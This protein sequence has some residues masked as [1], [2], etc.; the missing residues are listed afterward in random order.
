MQAAKN[1]KLTYLLIC[2]VA[3]VWGIILYKVL[4]REGEEE[5]KLAPAANKTAH[6]PYDQY[7]VRPDTFSLALSYRDP[8]LG[9]QA[10][11]PEPVMAAG[12]VTAPT[13]N[14]NMPVIPPPV[15]WSAIRYSGYITNPMS[16][17]LVSIVEVNG[18][19]RMLGEGESFQGMKL[20]KNKKDSILVSWQGKQKY[21][22]Q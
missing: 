13:Q 18:Q 9:G 1:K 10:P 7:A 12:N 14:F 21:I 2:A 8:F 4:F 3:A 20:L 15:N 17:R 11:A 19:E 6:E 22:R 16:K 5:Y